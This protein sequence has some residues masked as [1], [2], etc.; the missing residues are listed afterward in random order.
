[1]H[2]FVS[3]QHT[4]KAELLEAEADVEVPLQKM[5]MENGNADAA[6]K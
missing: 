1:M 6:G 2:P 5:E 3:L 4:G